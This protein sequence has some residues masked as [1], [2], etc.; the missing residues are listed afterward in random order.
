MVGAYRDAN[1]WTGRINAIYGP[2]TSVIGLIGDGGAAADRRPDGAGAATLTIGELTAFVLY[3]NAF[4]Q[5]VQQL[6][7]LY[8]QYQQAE[9]RDREDPRAAGDAVVG[10]AGRRRRRVAAGAG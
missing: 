9:G 4:F 8:T 3:V 6:V 1:D 5:P 10:A 7:Q 2:G